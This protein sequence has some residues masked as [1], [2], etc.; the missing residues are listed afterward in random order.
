MS[1][2]VGA[3]LDG[4]GMRDVVLVGHSLGGVVAFD[5][6]ARRPDVVSVLVVEDVAPPQPQPARVM[7]T[8]PDAE[9]P[10]DWDAL[11]PSAPRWTTRTPA[12]GMN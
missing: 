6:A 8:R 7:P 4:L 10:L 11:A 2:A 1:D 9:L 5:V 12:C 3:V